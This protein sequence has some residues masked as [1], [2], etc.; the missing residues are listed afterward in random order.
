MASIH[1]VRHGQASFGAD[2]YDQLSPLGVQQCRRLGEYLR[3][4]GRRFDG[5][6]IGTLQRHRQSFEALLEGLGAEALARPAPTV[7]PGLDEYDSH[8]VLATVHDGPLG[9][10]DSPEAYRHHFR[11]LREGLSRWMAGTAQP[12]GMPSYADFVAGV[13]GA[14]DHARQAFAGGEVLV[15]SSGGPISTAVGQVLGTAPETTIDLNMRI[16]NSALTELAITPKRY[17]LVTF[18]HLP[19]LDE[20]GFEGWVTH[21]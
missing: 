15:V 12:A 16:R 2:N 20:P 3:Q 18:N 8:A 10:P 17:A 21:T 11:L 5:A 9:R 6:L 14:L 4:R 13:R 19:H 1:L 7:L